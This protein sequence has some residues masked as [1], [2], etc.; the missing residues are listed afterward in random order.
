MP[1]L[2]VGQARVFVGYALSAS[3][4]G[5]LG[6]RRYFCFDASFLMTDLSCEHFWRPSSPSASALRAFSI[7]SQITV[8]SLAASSLRVPT[9]ALVNRALLGCEFG[10]FSLLGRRVNQN[11]LRAQSLA[12]PIPYTPVL[13]PCGT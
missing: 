13:V 7:S 1:P 4:L 8:L 6:K 3:P 10:E 5:S 9:F 11:R 12:R 2:D